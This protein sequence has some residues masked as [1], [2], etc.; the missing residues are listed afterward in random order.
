M[1]E[2]GICFMNWLLKIGEKVYLCG[3]LN[4]YIV[5]YYE[6]ILNYLILKI[7]IISI[8]FEMIF[9]MKDIKKVVMEG[10]YY[11]DVL[12]CIEVYY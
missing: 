3:I 9:G 1:I 2:N 6:Y 8:F 4:C 10:F 5:N 12:C 11:V 7:G